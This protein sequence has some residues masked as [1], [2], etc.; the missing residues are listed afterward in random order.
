MDVRRV[1][2]L[3]RH[4]LPRHSRRNE[5]PRMATRSPRR[6]NLL[7]PRVHI[8]KHTPIQDSQQILPLDC[9]PNNSTSPSTRS[10]EPTSRNTQ[11]PSRQ[12]TNSIKHTQPK[13]KHYIDSK[14]RSPAK[15]PHLAP[16]A[17]SLNHLQDNMEAAKNSTTE[18]QASQKPA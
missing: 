14:I 15:I 2:N 7:H 13:T 4:R 18:T 5:P 6:P 9:H 17:S 3:L 1:H 8:H 11:P 16:V 10:H 12:N